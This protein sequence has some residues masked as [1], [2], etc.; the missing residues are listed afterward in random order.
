VARRCAA[1]AIAC[2]APAGIVHG[3]GDF[4]LYVENDTLVPSALSSDEYYSQGLRLVV[5]REAWFAAR[6]SGSLRDWLG[7]HSLIPAESITYDARGSLVV[8]HTILTPSVITSFDVDP[9]DRPY[10]GY[11]YAGIR[12]DVVPRLRHRDTWRFDVAHSVEADVGFVGQPSMAKHAQR[13]FHVLR[14][15][16]IPKGWDHQ[17]GTEPS[18]N[19][20]YTWNGL[21]GKHFFDVSPALG[22]ALGTLQTY[23]T[24]GATVRVGWNMTGFPVSLGSW[25]A[26]A[27]EKRKDWEFGLFAGADGRYFLRNGY[28]DGNLI[29]GGPSVDRTRG[30]YDLRYGGFLRIL[31]W[32]L[33]YTLVR[34]SREFA[35]TP[36]YAKAHHNFG[37][38]SLGRERAGADTGPPGDQAFLRRDWTLGLGLGYGLAR[39]LPEG[40]VGQRT[41]HG[42]AGRFGVEK[43]LTDHLLLGAM[44]V[45]VVREGGPPD[46]TGTHRDTFLLTKAVTVGYR[47]FGRPQVGS[48]GA[49]H[50]RVGIGRGVGKEE[51]TVNGVPDLGEA[52]TG[53][54]LLGAVE[55]AFRLGRDLSLGV[56]AT[57]SHL[58]IDKALVDRARFLATS[59]TVQWRP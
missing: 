31:D 44:V 56:E 25:T 22:L 6:A 54:G 49:L 57:W 15:H 47:P 48:L 58:R 52:D 1:A 34:R 28:F 55:Y 13:G 18:L 7:N 9:R 5:P 4:Q 23:P 43:G 27:D 46:E 14:E 59:L 2:L 29:G 50:L 24:A 45:G 12:A 26:A 42:P 10:A 32:R 37:S 8:G 53:L 33:T 16:R 36:P 19:L 21:W 41:T 20:V 30:V 35:P 40:P 11:L 3:Q 38:V 51:L 17:L 39:L